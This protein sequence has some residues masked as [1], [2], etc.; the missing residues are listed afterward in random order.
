[1]YNITPEVESEQYYRDYVIQGRR[2][3]GQILKCWLEKEMDPEAIKWLFSLVTPR[4]YDTYSMGLNPLLLSAR[5]LLKAA[6]MHF[7][8][9]LTP[10]S[11]FTNV[12]EQAEKPIPVGF[13]V[14]MVKNGSQKGEHVYHYILGSDEK[15]AIEVLQAHPE[16]QRFRINPVKQVSGQFADNPPATTEFRFKTRSYGYKPIKDLL[17][18]LGVESQIKGMNELLAGCPVQV[19]FYRRTHLYPV[20]Q[21]EAISGY[22][23][24]RLG[25]V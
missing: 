11:V 15:P 14:K 2:I 19:F 6:D 7:V 21:R 17:G 22:I 25:V 10:I 24:K 3:P 8:P 20:T 12:L 16:L 13:L 9:S 23:L 5:R 18:E 1:M 4:F